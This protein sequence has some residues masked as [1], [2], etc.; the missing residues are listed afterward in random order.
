VGQRVAR[1]LARQFTSLENLHVEVLKEEEFEKL[2]SNR[3][4]WGP[5][6]SL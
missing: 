5:E 6:L 2:I 3:D 4:E 1:I